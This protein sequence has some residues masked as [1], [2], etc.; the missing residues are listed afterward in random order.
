MHSMNGPCVLCLCFPQYVDSFFAR[1]ELLKRESTS[2]DAVDY[3]KGMVEHLVWGFW[4]SGKLVAAEGKLRGALS[5]R[6]LDTQLSQGALQNLKVCTE[7]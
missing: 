3:E 6:R 7:Q 1:M 2:W 5:A 4:W